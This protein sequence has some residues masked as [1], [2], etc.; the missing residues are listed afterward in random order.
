MNDGH[1]QHMGVGACAGLGAKYLSRQ[2]SKTLAMLGSG[3]MARTYA[4]AIGRVRPIERIRVF[5]PTKANRE[6]YANEKDEKARLIA[7]RGAKSTLILP[8]SCFILVWGGP[9]SPAY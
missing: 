8:P 2:N 5:S 6:A 7:S 1:L 3:G 4:A 9:F